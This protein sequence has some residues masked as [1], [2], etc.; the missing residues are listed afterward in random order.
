MVVDG[1][2]IQSILDDLADLGFDGAMLPTASASSQWVRLDGYVGAPQI[3]DAGLRRA[4]ER[5]GLPEVSRMTGGWLV[6]EVAAAIAWP[7]VAVML[8]R[9]EVL[10]TSSSDVYL[11]HPSSSTGRAVR[12]AVEGSLASATPQTFSDGI[13][14]AMEPVVDGV[15]RRTRRGRHALWGTVTD[16]VAAAFLRVGDH[17]GRG[18]EARRVA[19]AVIDSS[20][21]LVGGT[22]W[23]DVTKPNATEPARV[24]NIC[25]LWYRTEGG[26]LC[27]TCPHRGSNR[28]PN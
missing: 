12:F 26:G 4:G 17:L 19:D 9:G 8:G 21:S 14:A 13:V 24:R 2:T 5:F 15:H 25:C 3:L 6:G 16:M 7:A 28:R 20:T 18:T 1:R 10:V 22:N 11:P 27:R 23:L